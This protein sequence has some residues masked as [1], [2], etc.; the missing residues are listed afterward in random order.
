MNQEV[1]SENIPREPS[2]DE[3]R[4]VQIEKLIG[5]V[6]QICLSLEGIMNDHGGDWFEE[7]VEPRRGSESA[8]GLKVARGLLVVYAIKHLREAG[9][10]L[11]SLLSVEDKE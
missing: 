8:T 11:E 1:I 2:V 4:K 10:Y 9:L 6:R 7:V 3:I 5:F